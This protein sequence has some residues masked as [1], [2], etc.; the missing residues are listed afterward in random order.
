MSQDSVR[1]K[2][3]GSPIHSSPGWTIF[4]FHLGQRRTEGRKERRTDG[5][6]QHA[7]C[8]SQ[9]RSLPSFIRPYTA[10]C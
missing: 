6:N 10:A 5:T 1:G 4:P 3:C 9:F 7:V 8:V 2:N